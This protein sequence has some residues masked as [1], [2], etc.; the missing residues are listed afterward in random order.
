MKRKKSG[1]EHSARKASSL[2]VHVGARLKERRL[3]MGLTQEVLAE[4]AG[5]AMQ[6]IQ[7]YESGKDRISA[8]RLFVLAEFLKV[9]TDWFF[10]GYQPASR[11]S[12]EIQPDDRQLEPDVVQL[13]KSYRRIDDEERRNMI[14]KIARSFARKSS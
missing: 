4:L 9:T 3:A 14:I 10:E 8:G 1:A 11:G 6:Q 5:I 2:D 12:K 13:I 7:K